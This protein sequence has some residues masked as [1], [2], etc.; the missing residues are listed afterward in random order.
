M[1][2]QDLERAVCAVICQ[3][4][5]IRAREIAERLGF[6]RREEIMIDGNAHERYNIKDKGE[7]ET[8]S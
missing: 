4:D 3:A 2:Q 5:G 8:V 7:R 1:T 6:E